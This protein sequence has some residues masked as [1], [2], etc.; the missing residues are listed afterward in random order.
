MAFFEEKADSGLMARM[1]LLSVIGHVVFVGFVLGLGFVQKT[2]RIIP[3]R[4]IPIS[5][6]P[7]KI[8]TLATKPQPLPPPAV[9]KPQEQP[10]PPEVKT[11][12]VIEK[13]VEVK[14]E[15]KPKPKPEATPKATP[16]PEATAKPRATPAPVAT[17]R[18]ATPA[19][20]QTPAQHPPAPSAPQ[21]APA[22]V[23]PLSAGS[24]PLTMQSLDLPTYYILSA[25]Q[26]IQSYFTIPPN[27]KNRQVIC[28]VTFTILKDGTITNIRVVQST[29]D[30]MLDQAAVRAI[31]LAKELG[32]LPDAISKTSIDSIITFDYSAD[33][34]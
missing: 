9:P 3:L 30:S 16:K 28:K 15:E 21:V 24:G 27:V 13:K 1:V 20:R 7:A 22:P 11:K 19:P 17:A 34:Q 29:G 26:K 6:P 8:E 14:K 31:T 18:P 25:R 12:K 33:W 32:P 23:A 2:P 4:L 5:G 10:R